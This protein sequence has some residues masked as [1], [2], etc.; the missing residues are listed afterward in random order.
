MGSYLAW[1]AADMSA[2]A[3]RSFRLSSEALRDWVASFV[4]TAPLGMYVEVRQE[5]RSDPQNRRLHAMIREAVAKGFQI[6]DRRFTEE[7]AKTLFVS[8][9]MIEQGFT[10][11][12]VKGLHDE[13]VQLR[14]STTTF[15]KAELTSLMDY[16]EMECAT[17]GFPL[18]EHQPAVLAR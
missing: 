2:M 14:R 9:W 13:P 8:G 10:S 1:K 4:K 16:I 7:E 17:R 12:I 15:G 6:G 5:P 3:P 11:D 18:R